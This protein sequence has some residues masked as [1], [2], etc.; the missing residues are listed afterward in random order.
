[1]EG[2]KNMSCFLLR[3]LLLIFNHNNLERNQEPLE[4]FKQRNY[5]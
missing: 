1:M 5:E 2:T 3:I 4:I